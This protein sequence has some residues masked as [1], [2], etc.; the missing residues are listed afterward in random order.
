VDELG[1]HAFDVG[2]DEE[3]FDGGVFA[4]VAVEFGIGGAPLRNS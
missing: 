3:L 4:H 1:V 2:E